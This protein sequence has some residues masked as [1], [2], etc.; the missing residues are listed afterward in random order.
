MVDHEHRGDGCSQMIPDRARMEARSSHA[1]LED[2]VCGLVTG[3]VVDDG[4][5]RCDI[6]VKANH[7]HQTQ[8]D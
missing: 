2:V 7:S 1:D 4:Q 3:N 8:R 5:K 6:G